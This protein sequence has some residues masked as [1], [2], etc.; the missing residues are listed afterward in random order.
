MTLREASIKKWEKII[1]EQKSSSQ[2]V[3]CYC[4]NRSISSRQFY[5]WQEILNSKKVER[6]DNFFEVE[7]KETY[8]DIDEP[9]SDFSGLHI[10]FGNSVTLE[11]DKDFDS[12]E[13]KKAAKILLSLQC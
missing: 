12:V 10:R 9:S 7:F 1:S 8:P 11:L 2:T 6:I 13:F 4:R 3:A 5:K